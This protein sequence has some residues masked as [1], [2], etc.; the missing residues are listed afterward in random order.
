MRRRAGVS[1]R[2]EEG[3]L[4]NRPGACRRLGLFLA[5]PRF[6]TRLLSS[7]SRR[8]SPSASRPSRRALPNSTSPPPPPPWSRLLPPRLPPFPLPPC[9]CGRLRSLG[10]ERALPARGPEAGRRK[11]ARQRGSPRGRREAARRKG[12]RARGCSD[13]D[14]RARNETEKRDGRRLSREAPPRRSGKARAGS[15]AG[16]SDAEAAEMLHAG[17]R[18][19]GERKGSSP[20]PPAL[21]CERAAE[22]GRIERVR[23]CERRPAARGR[24]RSRSPWGMKGGKG[25]G[26]EVRCSAGWSGA[27]QGRWGAEGKGKGKGG[28]GAEGGDKGHSVAGTREAHAEGEKGGGGKVGRSRAAARVSPR[29]RVPVPA[30]GDAISGARLGSAGALVRSREERGARKRKGE[31]RRARGAT[32][33]RGMG[34]AGGVR[35]RA[36]GLFPSCFRHAVPCPRSS[37]FDL[38]LRPFRRRRLRSRG[39]AVRQSP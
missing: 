18:E 1:K 13:G 24:L 21:P 32:R 36:L 23:G 28:R 37:P 6:Q 38:G 4:S 2:V 30:R 33:Q 9:S 5:A 26:G 20:P 29:G 34:K 17:R 15:G 14:A 19:E 3:W 10:V 11:G 25:G 22:I 31:A 27:R 12:V 7:R 35:W 39:R 16:A 8:A